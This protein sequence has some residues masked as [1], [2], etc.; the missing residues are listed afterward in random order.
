MRSCRG[1]SP[2]PSGRGWPEGPGE[3]RLVKNVAH[4]G[5]H[6]PLRGTLSRRERV[7]AK[8]RSPY[9][10]IGWKLHGAGLGDDQ[11]FAIWTVLMWRRVTQSRIVLLQTGKPLFV[12]DAGPGIA[13]AFVES[14]VLRRHAK[15]LLNFVFRIELEDLFLAYPRFGI[16]LGI[17][18]RNCQLQRIAIHAA[19]SLFHTGL[20]TDGISKM[21]EPGSLVKPE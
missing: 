20:V 10:R 7:L 11:P 14:V 18:K 5:P 2:S 6:P 17:V 9:S 19:I 8:N 3:G 13:D 15:E 21:I 1:A 12:D 4:S 16:G